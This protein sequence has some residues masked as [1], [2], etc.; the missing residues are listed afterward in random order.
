MRKVIEKTTNWATS[1]HRPVATARYNGRTCCAQNCVSTAFKTMAAYVLPTRPLA[2]CGAHTHHCKE[3]AKYM[4]IRISGACVKNLAC[5]LLILHATHRRLIHR[6]TTSGSNPCKARVC[7]ACRYQTSKTTGC[8]QLLTAC[9]APQCCFCSRSI[10]CWIERMCGEEN[11]PNSH[12]VRHACQSRKDS[13][14]EYYMFIWQL[15]VKA[16]CCAIVAF[17][18][19]KPKGA[20]ATRLRG[21]PRL[22]RAACCWPYST[23]HRPSTPR[24]SESAPQLQFPS[25]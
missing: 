17:A 20:A 16:L 12:R 23:V 11:V 3:Q 1:T 18:A 21:L 19:V 4:K 8:S 15:K 5:S 22:Q 2:V 9:W 10:I 7:K 24:P 13:A 14:L 25:V 6:T